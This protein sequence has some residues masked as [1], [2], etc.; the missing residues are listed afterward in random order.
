VFRDE[1]LD[2]LVGTPLYVAPEIIEQ[3]KYG[4]ECDCWSLGVITY[5]LLCGHEPFVS[6][7]VKEV[8]QKIIN[9]IYNFNDKPW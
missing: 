6:S 1:H 2:S 9:V 3:K 4:K 7:N 8:Y 5:L